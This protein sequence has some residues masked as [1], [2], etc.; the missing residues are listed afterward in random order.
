M[1]TIEI[2]EQDFDKAVEDAVEIAYDTDPSFYVPIWVFRDGT[3]HSGANLMHKNSDVVSPNILFTY[4]VE[5]GYA[6]D[7]TEEEE[8]ATKDYQRDFTKSNL[9]EQAAEFGDIKIELV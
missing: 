1:K 3:I 7:E 2:K 4:S 6:E 9:I 8:F 5:G